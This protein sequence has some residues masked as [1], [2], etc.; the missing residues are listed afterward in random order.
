MERLLLLWDELAELA[1]WGRHVALGVADAFSRRRMALA[2]RLRG[3]AAVFDP[4]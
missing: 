2:R 3:L 1:G 4:V